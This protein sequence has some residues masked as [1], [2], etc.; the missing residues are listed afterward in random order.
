MTADQAPNQQQAELWNTASGP[1]WVEMQGV[2]DRMLAPFEARLTAQAFPGEGRRVLDIGCGAGATT[3]AMARRLGPRGFAQGVD[4]SGSLVAAARDRA[5]AEGL[6]NA[7][8]VEADAQTHA[9]ERAGF[10][11]VISRFGVMFF[12]DPEAAFA[13]IRR[14]VRQ[15][16]RLTF[17]A[18]RSPLENSF[19]TAAAAAVAPI[20][21][22]PKAPEPGAPGQFAF[23]D[24]ERVRAILEA[25]GWRG[26]EVAPL[27]ERCA[28]AEAELLAYALN[29]GPVGLAL[30][31]AD[32]AT[33]R[34]AAELLD[35]AFAPFV[36]HGTARF[37]A[38]C[39]LVTATA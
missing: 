6:A 11:A 9:F 23:A 2:L 16:G 12:A 17:V 24:G 22:P 1:I 33:R 21:G 13:N 39:W 14:G 5:A 36:E 38:A 32:E 35:A 37:T 8:F 18:W 26:V 3:L 29:L 15:G 10:D 7:D 19:M 34:K 27:D 30:R 4:I 28:V 20:L 25:S 31:E